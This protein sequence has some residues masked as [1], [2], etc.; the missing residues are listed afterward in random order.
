MLIRLTQVN[1]LSVMFVNKTEKRWV[2]IPLLFNTILVLIWVLSEITFGPIKDI[3]KPFLI[4]F[5]LMDF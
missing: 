1:D 3:I 2:F 5:F 4:N